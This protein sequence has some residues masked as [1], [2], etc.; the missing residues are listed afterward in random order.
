MNK[1]ILLVL[2]A[3]LFRV[4]VLNG[5]VDT[6]SLDSCGIEENLLLNKYESSFLNIL[7]NN[8]RADFDFKNKRVLFGNYWE[9]GVNYHRNLKKQ[10]KNTIFNESVVHKFNKSGKVPYL[11]NIIVLSGDDY[12][13]TTAFD[14][15]IITSEGKKKLAPDKIIFQPPYGTPYTE[16]VKKIIISN[17]AKLFDE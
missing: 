7:Y 9:T 14:V 3:M 17:Y 2:F 5:Q 8:Y 15:L 10:P 6:L 4:S 13:I 1:S 12:E 11:G 16:E